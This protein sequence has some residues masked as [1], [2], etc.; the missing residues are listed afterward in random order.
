M[1]ISDRI[2]ERMEYWESRDLSQLRSR[3]SK[4]F[5]ETAEKVEWTIKGMFVYEGQPIT[6]DQFRLSVEHFALSALN[7]NYKPVHKKPL[8]KLPL[9]DFIYNPFAPRVKRLLL[10]FL[11]NEP[12]L[13]QPIK[14]P[15]LYHSLSQVYLKST[16]HGTKTC[17]DLSATDRANLITASHRLGNFKK[18]CN[19]K[20]VG[21]PGVTLSGLFMRH[22]TKITKDNIERIDTR[23]LTFNWVWEKFP[24]YMAQ[25][26][27]IQPEKKFSIYDR[28]GL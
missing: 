21:G 11:N 13:V 18:T 24:N 2:E 19:G 23:L 10:A 5:K 9:K 25:N 6:D 15:D 26:G 4:I 16:G 28:E 12:E 7:S 17:K 8:T 27:F 14:Y 3:N 1:K 22:V 20:I